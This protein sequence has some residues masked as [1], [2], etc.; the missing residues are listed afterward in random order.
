MRHL[1]LVTALL[2]GAAAGLLTVAAPAASHLWFFSEVFSNADGSIKFVE[3]KCTLSA[4]ENA[5]GGKWIKSTDLGDQF[6]FPS[7][8][9]GN[10]LNKTIL[11]AT[12]TFAD[13]PGAP[14]PDYIIPATFDFDLTGDTLTYW[15]Y[16]NPWA[17]AAIPTDGINSMN[18]APNPNPNFVAPNSPKNFAGVTAHVDLPCHHADVDDSGDTGFNDLTQLLLNWGPCAPA[19]PL[20][21]DG[22]GDVGFGDLTTVLLNWG[23]CTT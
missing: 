13:L 15:T 1:N 14:A 5:L 18:D 4:T 6:N 19:C 22:S 17:F 10:T 16:P 21:L 23:D 2:G 20:D 3:M 7:N 12:Q 11:I 9:V 8:I